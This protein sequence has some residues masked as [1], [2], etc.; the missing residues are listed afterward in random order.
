MDGNSLIKLA[1]M[2]YG[3]RPTII[4]GELSWWNRRGS[5]APSILR[6]KGDLEI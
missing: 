4:K 3:V 5:L 6:V 1:H 2:L